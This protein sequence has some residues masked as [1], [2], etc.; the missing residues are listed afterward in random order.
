[1]KPHP[2]HQLTRKD[3]HVLETEADLLGAPSVEK[4]RKDVYVDNPPSKNGHKG[5]D[6]ESGHKLMV[7]VRKE[8]EPHVRKHKVFRHEVD[9]LKELFGSSTRL[10]R[11][12]D[13]SVV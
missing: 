2:C 5:E 6:D 7:I 13:V 11:E 9:E 8:R 10:V 12:V 3:K 4:E 1:M